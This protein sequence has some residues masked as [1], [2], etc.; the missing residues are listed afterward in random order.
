MAQTR[1]PKAQL[2]AT[3]YSTTAGSITSAQLAGSLTDETGSGAVVL[4]TSPA[5]TTPTGIVKG[6]VGLG[7]VNDTSDASKPISTLTQTALD[8][9][10]TV[11]RVTFNN[12]NYTIVATKDTVV[13]QV[14]TLSAVRTVTLPLANTVLAGTE[15]IIVDQTGTATATN[16]IT[17][18]RAGADT[19]NGATSEDITGAYAWRRLI[20]DGTS[21]WNMDGGLVRL[22]SIQTL[23]NKTLTTPTISATG[24]TNA[25]H[26]HTA[27]TSGGQLTDAALSAAVGIA[28]GGTG[29][30]TKAAA[31]DA[32]SPA[33]TQ[34][35]IEYFN[36]TTN[37]RLAA[38]T[39]AQA[40]VTGGAGANP[41]WGQIVDVQK[42]TASGTWT[43]PSV[44][45]VTG[46]D[47]IVDVVVI[48][49]GGGGGSGRCGLTS[50][51]RGGGGGGSAGVYMVDRFAAS[52]LTATVTVTIPNGGTGNAAKGTAAANGAAGTSGGTASFGAYVI[53]VGGLGGGGGTTLVGGA[54]GSEATNSSF[55]YY[56]NNLGVPPAGGIGSVG[57]ASMGGGGAPAQGG[58]SGAGGGGGGISAANARDVGAAGG[59][60]GGFVSNSFGNK[61]AGGTAGAGIGGVGGVGSASGASSSSSMVGA[62]G[63]GGG[64]SGSTALGT[65][66]GAG[67][68]GG[69]YGGGGGGGG[70]GTSTSLSGAGG[71]GGKG[72]IWVITWR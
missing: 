12:A 40:L 39:A 56:N 32:L 57:D 3:L 37:T 43:K 34:G 60:A 17:I 72:V 71:N 69:A 1:I 53:A 20:S 52:D 59:A 10:R 38:G 51:L 63:G 35:D 30:V 22:N 45:S 54:G 62:P 14:G 33:T 70:A 67:G 49:S 21:S 15:F 27:A 4:G 25:Q 65:A 6:D 29:E 68:V 44:T 8:A 64:A 48:G 24:F 42:F 36:A 23:T 5:I 47:A 13:A 11:A 46:R 26:A 9:K 2:D 19:I 58:S 16:Y 28:K 61:V 41:A 55:V 7:N 18:A 66:G 31:Y 50:T